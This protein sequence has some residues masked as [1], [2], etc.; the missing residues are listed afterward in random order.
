MSDF[1]LAIDVGTTTLTVLI[2]DLSTGN[3]H[4]AKS[5]L[6]SNYPAPGLVEQDAGAI[7]DTAQKTLTTAL[8]SAHLSPNDIC[9]IGVTTQRSSIIV[10][11][12]ATGTPIT[13]MVVWSDQRGKQRAQELTEQGFAVH[14]QHAAAKLEAVLTLAE[15]RVSA[16]TRWGNIDSFLIWKLS[17]EHITDH[18]QAWSC[19]YYDFG[20]TGWNEA[21]INAQGLSISLFPGLVDTRGQVAETSEKVFGAKVPITA[22]VADQQCAL[23]AH[24]D[25]TASACKMT[26]GT[27]GVF[28]L[29]TGQSL[30]MPGATI[31]PWIQSRIMDETT[32]CIEG[33]VTSA[34][35][36]FDWLVSGLKATSAVSE[37][38]DFATTVPNTQGVSVLPALWGLGA[39]HGKSDVTG[40]I[41][42]LS[43][44]VTNAHIVRAAFEGVAFRVK[45]IV[46]VVDQAKLMPGISDRPLPVDGG[47]SQIDVFLQIQANVLQRPVKR[48]AISEA[49]A[50]GAALSAGL[51]VSKLETNQLQ[52]F[53]KYDRTFI[54]EWSQDYAEE[55]FSTWKQ[56]VF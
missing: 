17:G 1:I 8:Q 27:S 14:F 47:A 5:R 40:K 38:S 54:P 4:T 15:D 11:D 2:L 30:E 24:G 3:T 20:G 32:Y 10:W 21:L 48:H 13:P 36:M 6:S 51:G 34:G 25:L 22:I 56:S 35:A 26:Y 39:P 49:T 43:A 23:V 53:A 55:A 19:G 31:V 52:T 41:N 12:E 29:S 37:L 16:T 45:E 7:W 9:A 33:M 46:D 28:N 44:G 18:S 42:G 50:F